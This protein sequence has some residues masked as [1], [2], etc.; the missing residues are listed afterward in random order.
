M[1]APVCEVCKTELENWSGNIMVDGNK[2]PHV[3]DRLMVVCKSCT[4][5]LDSIKEIPRLHNIW[6]LSWVKD[7]ADRLKVEIAEDRQSNVRSWSDEAISKL[8]ELGRLAGF[9]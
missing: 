7:H 8:N 1:G 6:E 2:Y 4:N 3:I 5:K 9:N